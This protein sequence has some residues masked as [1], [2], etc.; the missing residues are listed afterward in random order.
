MY[1]QTCEFTLIHVGLEDSCIWVIWKGMSL[2]LKKLKVY[3][4][5]KFVYLIICG[6][7]LAQ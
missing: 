1:M 2:N 7:A 5:S 4:E 3:T 6:M